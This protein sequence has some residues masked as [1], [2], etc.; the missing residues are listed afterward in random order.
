MS[1]STR[2]LTVVSYNVWARPSSTLLPHAS[3]LLLGDEAQKQRMQEIPLAFKR[4]KI[5]PDV[6]CVQEMFCPGLLC[7]FSGTLSVLTK[8]LQR[9][10][11]LG[12]RTSIMN[13]LLKPIN[14]GLVIF[15]RY[16]IIKTKKCVFRGVSNNEKIM[17]KGCIYICVRLPSGEN[18]HF[19]NCHMNSPLTAE[20]AV[21]QKSQCRQLEKFVEN[22]RIPDTEPVFLCGDFNQDKCDLI[23][24]SQFP[25][26]R[27]SWKSYDSRYN[28]LV[29]KDGGAFSC[30]A[31]YRKQLQEASQNSQDKKSACA[32]CIKPANF[33]KI[34]IL[35]NKFKFQTQ[36]GRPRP[37]IHIVRL[38]SREPLSFKWE[39]QTFQ[40]NQLSDHFPVYVKIRLPVKKVN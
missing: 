8:G 6:I 2:S 22:M 24:F 28:H 29:G 31:D 18:A 26:E 27:V 23:G 14:S 37:K 5:K 25:Y 16:P 13:S 10:L 20:A 9:E 32:C 35:K 34:F 15:S 11:G 12:F 40:T 7:P 17:A 19:V 38:R 36:T 3:R 4:C 1:K 30:L 33:D 21:V 39:K